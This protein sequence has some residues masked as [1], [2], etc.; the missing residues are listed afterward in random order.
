MYNMKG[1]SAHKV[2]GGKLIRVAVEYGSRIDGIR[3]TGDF[4][5]HPEEKIAEIEQS[6]IGVSV[7]ID[8]ALLTARLQT[9]LK[10]SHLI[11]ASASDFVFAVKEACR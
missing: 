9:V 3:I 2:S 5:L 10:A 7:P 8:E 1:S 11:G 4:F 6:F